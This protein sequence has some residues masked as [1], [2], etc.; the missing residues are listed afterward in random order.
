M[1][2]EV[3]GEVGA[4]GKLQNCGTS[5]VG[6]KGSRL[7]KNKKLPSSR[8]ETAKVGYDKFVMEP[9][10]MAMSFSVAILGNTETTWRNRQLD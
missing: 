9:A 2:V 10:S 8:E 7:G 3:E 1:N 5:A 6:G 4:W